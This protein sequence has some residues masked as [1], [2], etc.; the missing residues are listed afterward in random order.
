MLRCQSQVYN[1]TED[2]FAWSVYKSRGQRGSTMYLNMF[3]HHLSYIRRFSQYAQ[4]YQCQTCD[5]HFKQSVDLNRHQ[6][7]CNNKTKFVY[8]GGFHQARVSIFDKLDQYE[9]HVPQDKRVFPGTFATTSRRFSKRYGNFQPRL[10]SGRLNSF[11]SASPSAA[12][13]RAIPIRYVS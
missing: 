3:E 2:D 11:L 7:S 1:L 4:K 5:R 12:M 10:S 8:P 9:I 13:W 6:K